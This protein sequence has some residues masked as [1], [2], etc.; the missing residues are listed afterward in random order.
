MAEPES[1]GA[2][3]NRDSFDKTYLKSREGILRAVGIVSI[4]SLRNSYLA[5]IY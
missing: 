3:E 1:G 5:S 4:F 2:G